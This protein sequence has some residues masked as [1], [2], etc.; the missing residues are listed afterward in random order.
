MASIETLTPTEAS[1]RAILRRAL[2]HLDRGTPVAVAVAMVEEPVDP[3]DPQHV[4]VGVTL[5][6]VPYTLLG[7]VNTMR[8]AMELELVS[9]DMYGGLDDE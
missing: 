7:A 3:A 6:Q 9:T 5:Q 2:Q 1:V 8:A 4:S